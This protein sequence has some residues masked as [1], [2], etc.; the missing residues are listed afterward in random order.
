MQNKAMP[1]MKQRKQLSAGTQKRES[2]AAGQ[3]TGIGKNNTR[4]GF[5]LLRQS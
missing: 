4:A 3:P 2:I 5:G 1:T